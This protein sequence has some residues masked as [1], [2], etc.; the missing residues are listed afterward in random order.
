MMQK[1]TA[2]LA[3]CA[4][5]GTV[6]AP[7]A[8]EARD[9]RDGYYDGRHHDGYYDNRR[10]HRDRDDDDGDAVAAGVIGLVLGLAL[11]A[12]ASQP[13]QPQA[14]CYDN[15]RRCDAPQGY[16]NQGYQ[17]QRGYDPR[18]DDRRS[19]YERD[20]G[21]SPQGYSEPYSPQR[22]QCMRRERQWDRYANRYVVVDVPC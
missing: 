6:L 19:A 2:M 13:R 12:A 7:P 4:L 10:R 3:A 20:Y 5:A 11:G 14:R 1:F 22:T 9:H 18:Y 21:A 8:A 15:Y 17:D 16:Y